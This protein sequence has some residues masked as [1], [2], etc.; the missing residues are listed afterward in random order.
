MLEIVLLCL[1]PHTPEP[2]RCDHIELNRVYNDDGR[3]WLEQVI[4][5]RWEPCVGWVAEGW[6]RLDHGRLRKTT[7][8]WRWEEPGLCVEA[9]VM[10]K[11]W[12]QY[13]HEA[14]NREEWPVASRRLNR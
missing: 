1:L 2:V 5:W 10:R 9:R 13:D 14:E 7:N 12:T 8:G 3:L 4:F 11:T 6:R